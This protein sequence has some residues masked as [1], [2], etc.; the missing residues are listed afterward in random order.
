MPCADQPDY[1][2]P[3]PD[4]LAA[5][6]EAFALQQESARSTSRASSPSLARPGGYRPLR[7]RDTLF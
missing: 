7:V 6:I 3:E 1:G 2:V 5:A 4:E